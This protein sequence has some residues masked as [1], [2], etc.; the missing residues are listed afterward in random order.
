MNRIVE[1]LKEVPIRDWIAIVGL[2][3]SCTAF[4]VIMNQDVQALKLQAV[5]YALQQE[6]RDSSQ[7]LV[8]KDLRNE[9]LNEVR[10]S[11]AEAKEDRKEILED[12]RE[13]RRSI[14]NIKPK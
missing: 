10:S 9:I 12:I 1:V 3:F 2:I 5:E 11:R 13:L 4:F 8:I 6:K 14:P 7:D